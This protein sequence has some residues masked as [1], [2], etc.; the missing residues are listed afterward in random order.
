M[1]RRMSK[2]ND[3]IGGAAQSPFKSGAESPDYGDSGDLVTPDYGDSLTFMTN[4]VYD[5]DS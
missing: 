5:K 4:I 2:I 1:G 3:E